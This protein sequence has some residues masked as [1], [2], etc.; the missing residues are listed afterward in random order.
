MIKKGWK[1]SSVL[2]LFLAIVFFALSFS[3]KWIALFGLGAELFLLLA[4]RIKD[5][6]SVKEGLF[7]KFHVF[8][9]PPFFT[10]IAF[11]A[12]AVGIYFLIYVPDM[13]AGR[14]FYDVFQLQVSMYQYHATLVATHPFSSLWWSWPL[15][16]LGP[17]GV[18]GHT[19]PLWLSVSYNLPNG[20][21]STIMA[22]GKSS[23]LVGWFRP[24][25]LRG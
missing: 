12:V 2:P 6:V 8:T 24:D 19:G 21:F 22:L 11:L 1:A 23:R 16:I 13:L 14:S 25:F 20:M 5:V 3:T 4:I 10:V 18:T 7:E 17:P 9:D 15:M